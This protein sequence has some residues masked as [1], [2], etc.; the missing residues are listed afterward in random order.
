MLIR[1]EKG[2]EAERMPRDGSRVPG[3]WKV[4][5]ALSVQSQESDSDE[6]SASKE[7]HL[8]SPESF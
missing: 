6:S 7:A 5:A 2:V 4:E 8:T 1:K 3:S